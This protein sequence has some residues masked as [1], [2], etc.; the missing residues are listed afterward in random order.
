MEL[1]KLQRAPRQQKGNGKSS[2]PKGKCYNYSKEGHFANKYRQ[3]KKDYS[4]GQRIA[5]LQPME[6]RVLTVDTA[7]LAMMTILTQ[8]SAEWEFGPN[9][10]VRN[11]PAIR[12]ILLSDPA[13]R[14]NVFHK[15]Y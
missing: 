5:K 4:Y 9:Q 11:L 8:D 10:R 15:Q 6:E 3:P 1:D 14:R 13:V 2:K 7:Q 12:R